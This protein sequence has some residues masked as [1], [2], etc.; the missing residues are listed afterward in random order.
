MCVVRE[1]GPRGARSLEPCR[2]ALGAPLGARSLEHGTIVAVLRG[3][4]GTPAP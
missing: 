2:A 3:A 1:G 4:L